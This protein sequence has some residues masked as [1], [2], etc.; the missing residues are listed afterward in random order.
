MAVVKLSDTGSIEW[1][2][3]L[4]GSAQDV[5]HSILQTSDNGFIACGFTYSTNEDITIN[6]GDA[7]YWIVKLSDSGAIQWQECLGGS[8]IDNLY[9]AIETPDSGFIAIGA[10]MSNDVD[11]RC[12]C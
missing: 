11:V 3:N 6:N 1:Q 10:S 8:N 12:Y 2:E 7:D 4:G 9:G 5:G